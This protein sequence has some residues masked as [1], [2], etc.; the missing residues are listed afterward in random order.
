MGWIQMAYDR[1]QWWAVL[2][3]VINQSNE[4]IR[5]HTLCLHPHIY[6]ERIIIYYIFTQL[7]LKIANSPDDGREWAETCSECMIPSQ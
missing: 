3:T 4:I 5:Q 7:K 1:V 6:C 2:N